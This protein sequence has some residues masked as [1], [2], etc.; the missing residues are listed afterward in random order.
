MERLLLQFVPDIVVIQSDGNRV[1]SLAIDDSRDF[2]GVTQAAALTFA[3][4]IS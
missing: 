1:G 3:S 2:A 4:G